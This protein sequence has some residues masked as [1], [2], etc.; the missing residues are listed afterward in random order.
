MRPRLWTVGFFCDG[1]TVVL[2]PFSKSGAEA[3]FARL[4]RE[5][6]AGAVPFISPLTRRGEGKPWLPTR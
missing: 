5:A 4:N 1:E 3:M 2:G 6:P